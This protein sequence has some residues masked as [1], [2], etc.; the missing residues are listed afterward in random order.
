MARRRQTIGQKARKRAARFLSSNSLARLGRKKVKA[1][2]RITKRITKKATRS[3]KRGAKALN[4][5]D[6]RLDKRQRRFLKK[7]PA[8][9]KRTRKVFRRLNKR[10]SK[11]LRI[12]RKE[13]KRLSKPYQLRGKK[14]GQ[15]RAE[16]RQEIKGT[17]DTSRSKIV[18]A[19]ADPG[20]SRPGEP[21]KMRSGQGRY[22]IK[23]EVRQRGKEIVSRTYVDKKI[24]GYMAMWEFRQD[25]EQRPFLKPGLMNNL[26]AFQTKVGAEL[27]RAA[28]SVG[29]RKAV[30]K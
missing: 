30:V 2:R 7:L 27:K 29:K 12:A 21:P 11:G 20:A 19:S 25:G 22:A 24:A 15:R 16:R 23:A 10:L 3:L 8:K 18:Q 26:S 1:A 17:F 5:F 6:K 14:L 13:F 28:T 9:I 4:R